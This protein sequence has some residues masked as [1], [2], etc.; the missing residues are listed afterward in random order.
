MAKGSISKRCMCIC[1]KKISILWFETYKKKRWGDSNQHSC[2]S[3]R[4]SNMLHTTRLMG[5]HE[6]MWGLP[7]VHRSAVKQQHTCCSWIDAT[8]CK[9]RLRR[10]HR[11]WLYLGPVSPNLF[12]T[13]PYVKCH[14][15]FYF[16]F[17]KTWLILYCEIQWNPVYTFF[18]G[19]EKQNI[20][21]RKMQQW[22]YAVSSVTKPGQGSSNFKMAV[23]ACCP[24]GFG[25][26]DCDK[27]PGNVLWATT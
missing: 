1:I 21:S 6:N 10:L 26:S 22:V 24:G 11:A 12:F 14:F 15:H 8:Y 3:M 23:H 18:S 27:W 5:K 16:R 2:S 20:T 13:W 17:Q 7:M 25:A 19:P 4:A 9:G